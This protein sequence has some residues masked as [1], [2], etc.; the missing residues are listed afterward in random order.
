MAAF[1]DLRGVG[2]DLDA[3]P[4]GACREVMT[5]VMCHFCAYDQAQWYDA[6]AASTGNKAVTICESLCDRVFE[7]CKN[8]LFRG[9]KLR[10][11]FRDGPAFCE[12]QNFRVYSD[13]D[14]RRPSQYAPCFGADSDPWGI[15]NRYSYKRRLADDLS[16]LPVI[17]SAAAALA[18]RGRVA[19]LIVA[20]TLSAVSAVAQTVAPTAVAHCPYFNNRAPKPDWGLANCTWHRPM[21]CCGVAEEQKLIATFE[22]HLVR[23]ESLGCQQ[24]L[25]YLLCWPCDGGQQYF[26]D[27]EA[28]EL[29]V[30][31]SFCDD[32]YP[33]RRRS[34]S[35]RR[36]PASTVAAS[37][38]IST[39]RP[40]R[41]L[42]RPAPSEHPRLRPAAAED[43]DASTS[44]VRALQDGPLQGRQF[45]SVHRGRHGVLRAA[46]G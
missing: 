4:G 29:S 33:R 44:Q 9:S 25:N 5:Y 31:R 15:E 26:Y 32:L 24:R 18:F 8:A 19:S 17:K 12:A 27:V 34:R 1:Q 36:S 23:D 3:P 13:G 35:S 42:P 43:L 22:E 20:L 46:A 28:N 40:R 6:D 7:A 10:N 21:S 37:N 45:G 41:R 11:A 30:C 16:P 14:Q 39:S 38:G 2:L